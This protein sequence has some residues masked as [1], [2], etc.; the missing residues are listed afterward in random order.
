M[1]QLGFQVTVVAVM[2]WVAELYQR[3]LITKE[4]LDGID[5]T[6]GNEEAFLELM[7]K[8][9]YREGIGNILANSFLESGTA[10]GKETL[11]YQPVITKWDTSED[12]RA[13]MDVALSH[14]IS[15]RGGD[16]HRALAYWTWFTPPEYT[17]AL[18]PG[19]PKE[20]I[21]MYSPVGKPE[22][23][24]LSERAHAICDM[25]SSCYWP[26]W[27]IMPYEGVV[28][29]EYAKLLTAATGVEYDVDKLYKCTERMLV[30][31]RAFNV[32]EGFDRSVY[33][34]SDLWYETAFPEGPQKGVTAD[35]AVV[36][37]M[38]DDFLVLRGFDPKTGFPTRK[39]MKK[40]G[41][42][43]EAD[44]LE[45]MGRIAKPETVTAGDAAP[46]KKK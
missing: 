6:W 13:R 36:K 41:L 35:R 40:V 45:K 25:L 39:V 20:A 5:L 42:S 7:R 26:S 9:A 1:Y 19:I 27:M 43:N 38:V 12:P 11:K 18:I 46:S 31:Q 22:V 23:V 17:Q 8:I 29:E 15:T 21:D 3:G 4:K 33:E 2:G 28:P 37:K 16:H 44:Q 32:R 10:L 14:L 30:L 24:E 34:M